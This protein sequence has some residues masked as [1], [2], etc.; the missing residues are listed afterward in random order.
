[1][2]LADTSVWIDH[3]RGGD[4]ALG[5]LLDQGEVCSHPY[6]IAELALGSLR[7]RTTVLGLLGDLPDIP[8]ATSGEL[9]H[10]I[11]ARGLD[12]AG[13]GFVDA[14]LLA[15]AVLGDGVRIWTRD[16]ALA[17]AAEGLG[18]AFEG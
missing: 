9:L 10:F 7:R 12:G 13:I 5:T 2:V 11:D 16:R 8:V 14:S 4:D 17:Q 1:M 15:S 3:L 18:V 6:V